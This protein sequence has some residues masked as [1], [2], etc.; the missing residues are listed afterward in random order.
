MPPMLKTT[1]RLSTRVQEQHPGAA[2]PHARQPL[3]SV[4]A[5]ALGYQRPA[6]RAAV[7]PRYMRE[8]LLSNLGWQE[9]YVLEVS[10]VILPSMLMT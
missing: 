8:D 7:N 1:A 5:G 4:A 10:R 2:D 3:E 6:I 9:R